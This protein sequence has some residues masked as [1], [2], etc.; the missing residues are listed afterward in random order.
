MKFVATDLPGVVIVEPQ[1]FGDARGFFMETYQERVFAEAGL[2]THFVQDNHSGSRQG[3]LRGL[4]YQIQQ[5][6]GKLV[7]AVA[8]EV[9]DVAV[10]LRKS[11]PYFGK[12]F[13][14]VLSAEN[15]RMLWVPPGFGHGYYVLSEW[16]E[17]VYKTTDFYA[18]Q[19]ERTLRW[20]DLQVGVDWP[21][22]A[23]QPPLLS[24]KDAQGAA[25][26]EAEVFE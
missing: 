25:L 23:G 26:A 2:P 4:H 9:F 1:V 7:R 20:D 14:L 13:G 12:W 10:D 21:L 6:Q 16:A 18:P 3:I 11:S 8:G 5:P 24:T 15:K 19:W 17:F 22:V